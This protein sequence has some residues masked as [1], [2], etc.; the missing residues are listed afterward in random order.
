MTTYKWSSPQSW[1]DDRVQALAE[2]RDVNG[3]VEVINALIFHVDAD[4]IQDVFQSEMDSDGYFKPDDEGA[5]QAFRDRIESWFEDQFDYHRFTSENQDDPEYD[6]LNE[7]LLSEYGESLQDT[8]SR[9]DG[10][11]D[12]M[13]S[14]LI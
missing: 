6:K 9:Y 14:Y 12:R 2:K 5:V 3:L 11:A 10:D 13:I 7:Y 4:Q 8:Y 1:L